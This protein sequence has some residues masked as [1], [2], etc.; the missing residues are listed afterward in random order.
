MKIIRLGSKA[1]I[2][3]K[4][5]NLNRLY[6]D[7]NIA[8][9]FIVTNEYFKDFLK[10]NKI[11]INNFK[12]NDIL[13]GIMP[14]EEELLSLFKE[15]NLSKVIVRSS[16]GVEDG[17]NYSFAGQ[18][19]SI[20]DVSI[21]SLCIS[22]KKCWLSMFS[23]NVQDYLKIIDNFSFD[24]LVQEM[25]ISSVAGIAF[26]INPSNG[27]KGILVEATDKQC[28]DLVSGKVTPNQY[29]LND[30]IKGDNL[31][32]RNQLLKIK[33]KIEK[34]KRIFKKEVEIEF[35]FKDDMFYL[36]QV[37]PITKVYFSLNN[38][39]KD[40]MWCCF[41]N[42]NWTLFMRSLWILGAT[43]YKHKMINNEVTEDF[44]LYYP[45]NERQMRGFNG[46]QPPL[47]EETV[48][49]HT[50]DDINRYILE[51]DSI[52]N[53][54]KKLS[55]IIKNNIDSNN[56]IEFNKNL[57]KLIK[58]NAF[59]NSYEYLIGSL[60][61][62]M[63]ENLNLQT[64]KNIEK[65]RNSEDNSYFPIYDDIFDYIYKYFNVEINID[66]FKMYAHVFEVLNL[67]AGKLNIST[68]E[69]R[70]ALREKKGFVLLN[71]QNKKYANK[72]N[73][74]DVTIKIAKKIFDGSCSE[75]LDNMDVVRGTSTFKNGKIIEGECVVVKANEDISKLDLNNKI[76][77]CEIT[78]AKDVKYLKKIKAII[79]NSGGILCHSAIFSREFN[80]PCLMGCDVATNYFK[81][82]DKI[83]F[84][85]DGE[86]V[87]KEN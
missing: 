44:T 6:N 33:E 82:G 68:L 26:S 1:N 39:L 20:L 61:Q 42:N 8:K 29:E 57:K 64:I 12:K 5:G 59:I 76:L 18:F 27:K 67:C 86:Y 16:A 21:D 69:K 35:A 51:H 53:D 49:K 28:E 17:D 58:Y 30:N 19:D 9:G 62:A 36:F 2:K 77:V 37:R 40:E 41:K 85:V 3:G 34:L 75:N 46:S 48:N 10:I 66:L 73:V 72:V 56:F 52:A 74:D 55:V 54:I 32:T 79:V 22:I 70:I 38:Y 25:V 84:D 15:C 11:D 81:T 7:F 83:K 14:I 78:T 87:I 4:A 50:S 71:L 47:D 24:V 65:W 80:I 43:K 60:G 23:D 45:H 31:L 63:H 13:N